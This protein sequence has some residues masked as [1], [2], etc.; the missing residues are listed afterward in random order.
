MVTDDAFLQA[1][2]PME[3]RFRAVE[4]WYRKERIRAN[5]RPYLEG[6]ERL[7]LQHELDTACALYVEATPEQRM[8]MRELFAWSYTL[9]GYLQGGVGIA[10]NG[11]EGEELLRRLRTGLAAAALENNKTDFRDMYVALGDMWVTASLANVDPAPL[12]REAAE[13]CSDRDDFG[14]GYGS[15]RQFLLGF[16]QSAF[17]EADVAPRVPS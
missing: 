13:W 14:Y 3:A 2:L 12:F 10:A 9:P 4:N 11:V 1:W 15:M 6:E 17:F 5:G 8:I 16:E 7:S